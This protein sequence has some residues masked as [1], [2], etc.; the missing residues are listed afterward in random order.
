MKINFSKSAAEFLNEVSHFL[1]KREAEYSLMLGL[2]ELKKINNQAIDENVYVSVYDSDH[3]IGALLVNERSLV[4]TEFTDSILK[5]I[6]ESLFATNIKIPAVVGPASTSEKFADI[7]G[8]LTQQSYKLAMGQKIYQLD[9]VISPKNTNGKLVAATDEYTEIISQ[10]LYQFNIESLPHEPATIQKALNLAQTKI[11][12]GEIYLWLDI[13]NKPVSMNLVTR[14]TQNGISIGGVYTPVE[15]RKNGYASATVAQTSQLMLSSGKKFCVLYTDV[16]NPTSNKIY[17][18][19]GYKEI[20][21]SQH[22]IF[23][24]TKNYE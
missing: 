8:Q 23:E 5:K 13:Q 18:N 15:L 20:A 22:F 12:K 24:R 14:P 21:T 4:I 11:K 1:E 19:I 16:E 7:W 6:A 9:K 3:L 17:Q 10:W 2:C